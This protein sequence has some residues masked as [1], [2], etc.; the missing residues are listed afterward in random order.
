MKTDERRAIDRREALRYLAGA[1]AVTALL[2]GATSAAIARKFAPTADRTELFLQLSAILTGEPKAGLDAALAIEYM[3]RLERQAPGVLEKL[4]A[5]YGRLAV[6]AGTDPQ[7]LVDLVQEK[8]WQPGTCRDISYGGAPLCDAS[9]TPECCLARDV[10][11]LWYA[12]SLMET[13]AMEVP[14]TQFVYGSA[15]SYLG[16]LAWKIGQAHPQA[17]CGGSYGYWSTAPDEPHKTNG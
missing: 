6:E 14:T 3:D 15:A 12:G 8:I 1:L 13:T 9:A 16:A 7:R 2:P 5:L 11:L 4:L 17:Q 10:V